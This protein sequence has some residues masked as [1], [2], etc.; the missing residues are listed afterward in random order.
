MKTL[1]IGAGGQGAPCASILA[2]DGDV[3]RV[4][5]GDIDLE[6][7]RRVKDKIGSGKIEA[8]GLDAGN[9]GE[10]QDAAR[11]VD[12]IINLTHFRFNANIMQ[13]ALNVGA[14]YVDT[15]TGDLIWDQILGRESL[16][17]DQEFR[18]A[19]LSALIGCG[20]SPGVT[21]VLT[22]YVCDRL[23]EVHRISIKLG[24]R[25]LGGKLASAWNPG[26]CPQI[27]LTDYAD[28]VYVFEDGR[29]VEHPPFS[30]AEEVGFPEP[31]GSVLLTRHSHEEPLLIGHFMGERVRYC[32]F[33]YSFD[34]I[35]G[36]LVEMGFANEEPIDVK[37]V[38]VSPIDLISMTAKRP[39]DAFLGETEESVQGGASFASALTVEV[40][41]REEG[42]EVEYRLIM[43]D[44]IS[45]EAQSRLFGQFGTTRI[46]VALPAVVG[47]KMC[48]RGVPKGVI[49]P[50][51][52]DPVAF[53]KGMA[54]MGVPLRFKEE[55]IKEVIIS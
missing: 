16:Y 2:R 23:D 5:L 30:A 29:F 10:I 17:L 55:R 35:A 48:L 39:V 43:V 42:D 26:W 52:L 41:G 18:E 45:P 3:L 8:V 44:D 15:A 25:E 40:K 34:P 36:A 12:V 54:A 7:A 6:L 28:S 32:E 22:K 53:L 24:V 31:V 4:V 51:C 27:A 33:K 49:A 14:H 47:A 1:I 20:L 13:A 38:Q 37:G 9:V 50:E 46:E 19:G 11:G 21:D